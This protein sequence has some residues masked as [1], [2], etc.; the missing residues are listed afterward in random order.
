MLGGAQA[1]SSTSAQ[2]AL[3]FGIDQ[4]KNRSSCGGL[5]TVHRK[6][7]HPKP[8]VI[9]KMHGTGARR[10]APVTF[11]NSIDQV[12]QLLAWRQRMKKREP[13]C[14][15]LE[16]IALVLAGSADSAQI[17]RA[18]RHLDECPLCRRAVNVL[19]A[20]GKENTEKP[21]SARSWLPVWRRPL[22]A[23]SACALLVL[24]GVLFWK[25]P[26][27]A[28]DEDTLVVK[29]CADNILIAVENDA[30]RFIAKNGG[31]LRD[32]D[33]LGFFYSA[34]ETGY[35]ALFNVHA[36]GTVSL[37][38]PFGM[39][40]SDKIDAGKNIALPGNGIVRKTR[41]CEW[42]VGVFSHQSLD[43]QELASSLRKAVAA[44]R[45]G[46]NID[47]S[48]ESARRVWVFGLQ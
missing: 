6:I 44:D 1:Q 3:F 4:R 32:G 41:E 21:S 13:E 25:M 37:L 35:L 14:S 36:A 9:E 43:T 22:V 47:F 10:R 45:V 12:E 27:D 40:Q 24:F 38:F 7:D 16:N 30:R 42:L 18:S 5:K 20:M 31:Q 39:R 26:V 15:D 34:Q 17:K 19:D 29:G 23:F 8:D 2:I 48:I 11:P 33:R 28:P 46:C